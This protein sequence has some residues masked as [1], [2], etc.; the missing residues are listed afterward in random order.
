MA[1]FTPEEIENQDFLSTLRG[2]DKE[3]V[4]AFLRAVAAEFQH[5]LER[6]GEAR[7]PEISDDATETGGDAPEATAADEANRRVDE[8]LASTSAAIDDLQLALREEVAALRSGRAELEALRV[9]AEETLVTFRKAAEDLERAR[10]EP[11]NG[12]VRR[13]PPVKRV[14]V[15]IDP[16]NGTIAPATATPTPVPSDAIVI[17][18]PESQPEDASPDTSPR[19]APSDAARQPAKPPAQWEELLADPDLDV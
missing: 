11:A 16:S 3:E 2:Y 4:R 10:T 18:E 7:T 14:D 1:A 5:L 19:P 6:A 9:Q 13:R 8:L 12:T 15:E 17:P